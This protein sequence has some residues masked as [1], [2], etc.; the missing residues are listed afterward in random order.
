MSHGSKPHFTSGFRVSLHILLPGKEQPFPDGFGS[1]FQTQPVSSDSPPALTSGFRWKSPPAHHA[2]KF[3]VWFLKWNPEMKLS[4]TV[5][6]GELN[7]PRTIPL[8]LS[9]NELTTIQRI[10]GMSP[11]H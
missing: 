8:A 7:G 9:C 3:S 10:K 5:V 2:A 6:S 11:Q 4:L 1:G